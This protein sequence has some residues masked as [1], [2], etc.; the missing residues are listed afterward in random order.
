M[1]KA[2]KQTL[3]DLITGKKEQDWLEIYHVNSVTGEKTLYKKI[4]GSKKL[5]ITVDDPAT[6]ESFLKI[7]EGEKTK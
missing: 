1:K 6:A 5:T 3:I 2:L 4:P 7:M